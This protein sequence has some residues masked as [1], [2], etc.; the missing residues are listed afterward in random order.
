MSEP[1]YLGLLFILPWIVGLL[2]FKLIPILASLVLSFTDFF[3]LEPAQTRFIGL[4]NYLAV[5]Q[6]PTSSEILWRTISQAMQ[7]IPLQLGASIVVAA[8]LS[9][10]R[11]RMKN[12]VRALFFLPS[13]IPATAAVYMW[14]S[15]A[16][17]NGWLNRLV[18]NPFGLG[19]LNRLAERGA[20]Q[21]LFLLNSVWM[22]GPGMLIIAG[23]IQGIA[24]EIH[25]AAKIDGAGWLRRFTAITLPLITPAIFF[26]IILN[27]TVVFGG[28]IL[29]DRGHHFNS[30]LS[31]YDGYIHSV[32]FGSFKLGAASSLAWTFFA[33]SM[34][35][36]LALFVTS[37]FWVYFPEREQ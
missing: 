14:Q 11:L 5:L 26:S 30:D 12:T 18:L 36:V 34:A 15:F 21:S 1:G 13:I 23:A 25:E 7:I 27:L 4:E 16:S 35:I 24:P 8:I 28:A 3:L 31:S 9:S 32:L 33:F 20:G 6:D 19:W 17:Q 22:L 2:L 37:K 10:K 29:L